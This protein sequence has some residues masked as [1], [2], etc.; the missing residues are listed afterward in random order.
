MQ[1]AITLSTDFSLSGPYVALMKAVIAR[2]APGA[3]IIDL[4]HQIPAC[5]RGEAAFW[6]S[7]SWHWFPAGSVHVAV[8]DPGVGT[9]RGILAADHGGHRFIAPDNGILPMILGNDVPLYLLA[10]GWPGRRDWPTPS[11][12]FH[13]RDIFAPLAAT[14]YTGKAAPVDIGPRQIRPV[15]APVPP[16]SIHDGQIHGQVV[17][18][19]RWGNLIT[20]I[21]QALFSHISAAE[22]RIGRQQLTL[23]TTYGDAETGTLL[24][25]VNSLGT[26][27]IACREGNAASLLGLGRGTP[28]TIGPAA[29]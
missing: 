24:A 17:A 5:D 29:G 28:V 22:I 11:N 4:S 2:Y 8:V 10:E 19:D 12:S 27:E 9:S 23:S 16:P 7:R 3:S 14:L 25:L 15:A 1:P 21:D 26:L 18:I 6:I 13:G 20:N